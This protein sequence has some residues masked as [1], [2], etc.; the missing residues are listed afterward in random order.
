MALFVTDRPTSGGQSPFSSLPSYLQV[1][2]LALSRLPV[3]RQ[4]RTK[5]EGVKDWRNG[6][7]GEWSRG[8]PC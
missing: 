7:G 1:V 2:L 4:H 5:V 3:V 6:T 8:I